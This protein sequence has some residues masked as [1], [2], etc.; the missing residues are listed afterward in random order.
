[1]PRLDISN[2]HFLIALCVLTLNGL[3]IASYFVWCRRRRSREGM[4]SMD[5]AEDSDSDYI[6]E[7][8]LEMERGDVID[9]EFIT[10]SDA[11]PCWY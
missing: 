3:G 4:E 7:S 11:E 9:G 10:D 5:C 6:M 2:K 8:D 1:M